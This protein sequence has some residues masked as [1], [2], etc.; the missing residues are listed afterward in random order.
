M[1]RL[2]WAGRFKKQYKNLDPNTQQDVD[3]AVREIASSANPASLGTYKPNM[4]VF[5]YEIGRKYRV[6][7][8]IQYRDGIVDLLRV[9]DYKSAYGKE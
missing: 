7:Y 5:A 3:E 9:C 4:R 8:S 2:R 1:W 6:I